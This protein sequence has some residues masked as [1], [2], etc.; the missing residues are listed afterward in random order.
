MTPVLN[1]DSL[2]TTDITYG[3]APV[4]PTG[5]SEPWPTSVIP[6]PAPKPVPH[7]WEANYGEGTPL[8]I[9]QLIANLQAIRKVEGN[10]P[11]RFRNYD[12]ENV[13]A[14]VTDLQSTNGCVVFCSNDVPLAERI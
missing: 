11:C 13:I 12:E 6:L 9:D 7:T 10:L 3:E 5:Y 14:P 4:Y 8:T 1:L 2:T